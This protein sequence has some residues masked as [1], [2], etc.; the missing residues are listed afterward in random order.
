MPFAFFS[1]LADELLAIWSVTWYNILKRI[2]I[3]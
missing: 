3:L 2:R 1:A